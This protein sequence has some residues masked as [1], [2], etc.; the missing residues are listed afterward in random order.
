LGQLSLIQ[1]EFF[2]PVPDDQRYIHGD[3]SWKT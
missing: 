3:S 2:Q 1:P